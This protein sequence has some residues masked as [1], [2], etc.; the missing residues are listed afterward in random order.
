MTPAGLNCDKSSQITQFNSEKNEDSDL[1]KT[2]ISTPSSESSEDCSHA[3]AHAHTRTRLNNINNKINIHA[4][5]DCSRMA[6]PS[7]S[8]SSLSILSGQAEG[9]VKKSKSRSSENIEK[10][11]PIANRI[12]D[13]V[14]EKIRVNY[15]PQRL[16]QWASI[17]SRLDRIDGVSIERQKEA[18]DYYEMQRSFPYA[19]VIDSAQSFRDK[20]VRLETARQRYLE[21]QSRTS[22]NSPSTAMPSVADRSTVSILRQY[23]PGKTRWKQVRYEWCPKIQ[24]WIFPSV[25]HKEIIVA[26]GE[27]YN[28]IY[29]EQLKNLVLLDGSPDEKTWNVLGRPGMIMDDYLDWLP[30]QHWISSRDLKAF[31]PLSALFL[32]FR[33]RLAERKDIDG[34]DVLTGKYIIK[35]S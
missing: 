15:S 10:Y 28:Y 19:L 9:P 35:N 26:L 4:Q 27:L 12:A 11:L 29:S 30:E 2:M 5:D 14:R 22:L 16:R 13:L 17:L 20:Y 33:Q 34:R 6:S 21:K 23:W 3:H 18:L 1:Q 24:S 7:L 32:K 31:H 8:Q 25:D